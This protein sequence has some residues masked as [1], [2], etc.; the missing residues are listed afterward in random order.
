LGKYYIV[1]TGIRNLLLAGSSAD[2]GHLLENIIYLELIRRGFKVNTGK[3]G[4]NEVDFVAQGPDGTAY[5]QSAA[6]VMDP[7]TLERELT[8][9]RKIRDNHPKYLLTLDEYPGDA[10]YD[11]IRQFNAVEWLLC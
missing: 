8:P 5:Y 4:E 10:N 7:A 11:G 9:L 3:V 2:L 6:S 1:D